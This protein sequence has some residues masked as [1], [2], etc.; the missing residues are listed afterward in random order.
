MIISQGAE[1]ILRKENNQLIKERISK[2]YRI[3]DLDEKIRKL[4]TRSESKLL[5]K[6][7][8][9]I[10]VP[11]LI[12]SNDKEMKIIMEFIE[13]EKLSDNLDKFNS[14]KRDKITEEIGKNTALLHNNNII[15]GDLTTSN[16]IL[17][18][19]EIYFI[20]FGLG[21]FSIKSEDKAVDI[22]LFKQALESKHYRHFETSFENFLKGYKKHTSNYKNIM[23]RLEKVEKRG[24]YKSKNP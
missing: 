21:F 16:M 15:H 12:D 14:K 19:E 3:N 13:G 20:D 18:N 11:K 17:K 2:N 24:R 7:Y 23:E 10:K 1:A 9:I 22:H 4:R 5:E 8:S 6:A